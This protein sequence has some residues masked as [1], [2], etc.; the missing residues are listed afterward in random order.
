MQVTHEF[1]QT[2]DGAATCITVLQNAVNTLYTVQHV[3]VGDQGF[4]AVND[5][6]DCVY[7]L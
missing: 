5:A 2:H 1:M 7:A 6:C 4:F 3:C